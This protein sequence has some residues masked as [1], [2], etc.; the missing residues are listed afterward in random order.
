MIRN[1]SNSRYVYPLLIPFLFIFSCKGQ[2]DPD[3][4]VKLRERLSP[5]VN[6]ENK[7]GEVIN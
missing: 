6:E 1:N 3:C 7:I 4:L 2:S 5:H